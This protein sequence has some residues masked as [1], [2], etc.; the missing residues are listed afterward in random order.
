MEEYISAST[1]L[2]KKKNLD[3]FFEQKLRSTTAL[4][5]ESETL[6]HGIRIAD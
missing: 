1:L 6:G 2:G 5:V 4:E 3:Q